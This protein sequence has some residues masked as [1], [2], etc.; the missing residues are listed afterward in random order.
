[1]RDLIR[2]Y[3]ADSWSKNVIEDGEG[4][5][6]RI[7]AGATILMLLSHRDG[8][9]KPGHGEG[10]VVLLRATKPVCRCQPQEREREGPGQ[11]AVRSFRL[12]TKP[13]VVWLKRRAVGNVARPPTPVTPPSPRLTAY[14][15]MRGLKHVAVCA[16]PVTSKSIMNP[17]FVVSIHH[18]C[19]TLLP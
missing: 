1:M 12:T 5:S 4:C 19:A 13:A 17:L 9:R 6:D 8:S 15:G 14:Q 11:T 10:G 2:Q 18:S 7:H 3:G 16:M